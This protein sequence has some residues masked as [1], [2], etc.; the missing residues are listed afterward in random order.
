MTTREWLDVRNRHGL[1]AAVSR[2]MDDGIEDS[3][4][5]EAACKSAHYAHEEIEEAL[6]GI[7][8]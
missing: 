2:A 1:E 3:P 4:D 5:L 8:S 6:E 7:G